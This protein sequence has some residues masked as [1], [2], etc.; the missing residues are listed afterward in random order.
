[1]HRFALIL[2]AVVGPSLGG[3][4][5]VLGVECEDEC[6][7]FDRQC[8]VYDVQA[9]ELDWV[10]SGC[11]VWTFEQDCRDRKAVCVDGACV[12]PPGTFDCGI[13][14]DLATDP[15]NCGRCGIVCTGACSNGT[16]AP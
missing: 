8:V 11:N 14:V 5:Q 15:A 6:A 3:C 7:L 10:V 16:C 1:M 9:C 13:C 12:C 2:V 4:L